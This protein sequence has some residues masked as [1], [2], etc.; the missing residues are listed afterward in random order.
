MSVRPGRAS[1]VLLL[2]TTALAVVSFWVPF[3]ALLVAPV[4]LLTCVGAALDFQALRAALRSVSLRQ[5]VPATMG[6]DIPFTVSLR[7]FFPSTRRFQVTVRVGV[8]LQATPNLWIDS[9]EVGGVEPE[10]ELARD[11]RIAERGRFEFGPVWV[12]VTGPFGLLE[13]QRS[14]DRA[15]AVDILPESFW[16]KEK[17]SKDDA[18]EQ[19]LL[20]KL[21]RAQRHGVGTEFESLVEFRAGEDPQR[22]D[23]RA[24]ARTRRLIVRRFQVEQHRDVMIVVDCGRLM[25]A[26]AQKGT[27]LDCAVDAALMLSRVALES[28][29]RC[30]LGVFDDQVLGYLPPVAGPQAMRALTRCVYDLQTGFRESDFSRM[31]AALQSRQRK[32]S[33][34]VVLSDIVDD[35]TTTRFRLSLASLARRHVV[36]FAALKTPLLSALPR[37]PIG[38][39]L[40]AARHA[41]AYRVLRER[42]QA[43]HSL[44]R[45][46]V[47]VL[48]V[49]PS[50]LTIPLINQYV[51]LRQRNTL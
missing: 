50:R 16:S 48:D 25:G 2:T 26:D 15:D 44:Q 20:D 37:R 46:A 27:K 30:G 47:H 24:T 7:I 3:A 33:L 17:L 8:P 19:R 13:M 21:A 29:D 22:I 5:S 36:I 39:M 4:L 49:E 9:V 12:R 42:E 11:F 10:R 43:V 1:I 32:R 45:S 40:D 14:F 35:E 51:D 34:V 6:R 31:F 18:D 28:G 38:S 41:V 23:W